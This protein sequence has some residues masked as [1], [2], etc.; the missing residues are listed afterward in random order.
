M[1]LARKDR[2]A[3]L[4][5]K[6]AAPF[7]PVKP[8]EPGTWLDRGH[9]YA[10]TFPAKSDPKKGIARETTGATKAGRAKRAV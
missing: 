2:V 9:R 3:R 5:L 4:K 6:G 8:R 7:E 1:R 10:I